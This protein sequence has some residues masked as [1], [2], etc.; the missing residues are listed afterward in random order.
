MLFWAEGSKQRNSVAFSNSDVA[1]HQHFARFLRECYDVPDDRIR[2]SVNCYLGNGLSLAEIE[3]W[4]LNELRLP[5]V[6][7]RAAVVNRASRATRFRRNRLLYGTARLAVHSTFIT[8]SIYGAIQE[9]TGMDRP[10]WLDCLPP[11]Q[12]ERA[13]DPAGAA[14]GRR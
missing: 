4:W 14:T 2:L 11:P 5:R 1:M 10:E 9:Y 3:G 12:L 7:L 13:P 6:S 8:Q